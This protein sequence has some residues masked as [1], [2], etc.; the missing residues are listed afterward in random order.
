MLY[1]TF[2]AMVRR[3]RKIAKDEKRLEKVVQDCQKV[4]MRRDPDMSI[5]SVTPLL[6]LSAASLTTN[7]E[8]V[9]TIAWCSFLPKTLDRIGVQERQSYMFSQDVPPVDSIC[10]YSLCKSFAV[11]IPIS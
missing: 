1:R 10:D 4:D 3:N 6:V 8:N 9:V 11:S 2:Y 5:V 7:S